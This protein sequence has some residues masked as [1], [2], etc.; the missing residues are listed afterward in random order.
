MRK[1]MIVLGSAF[2]GLWLLAFLMAPVCA[3]P[4]ADNDGICDADDPCPGDADNDADGDGI[5][6]DE[7]ACP[8]DADNDADGDGI[9]GDLDNCPD[10]ANPGQE[11]CDDDGEGD[12]CEA[13]GS[14]V[15]NEIMYNPQTAVDT[16]GEW[17]ELHNTGGLPIDITGWQIRDSLTINLT[18]IGSEENPAI[19]DCKGFFLLARNSVPDVNGGLPEVDWVFDFALNNDVGDSVVL[20]KPGQGEPILVDRVDY[21][22]DESWPFCLD[23]DPDLD[24]GLS[25]ELADPMLD[26]NDGANWHCASENYGAGD[27]GTPKAPNSQGLP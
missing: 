4:D 11:D 15:I 25:I 17:I 24:R 5:C 14:V 23:P 18:T 16:V 3:C 12:A 2:L 21:N 19:I 1:R 22:D 13:P 9:C 27:F 10:T 20:F 8:N 6:G 7:D 26:N